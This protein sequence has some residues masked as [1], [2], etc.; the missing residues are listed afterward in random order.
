MIPHLYVIL[1]SVSL[2]LTSCFTKD[3]VLTT[4]QLLNKIYGNFVMAFYK[5]LL[6]IYLFFQLC[7]VSDSSYYGY[8]SV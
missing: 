8:F 4:V 7:G 2:F 5:L 1:D 6:F 3:T